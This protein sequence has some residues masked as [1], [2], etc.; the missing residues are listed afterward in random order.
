MTPF[1]EKYG[2]APCAAADKSAPVPPF[3]LANIPLTSPDA[4]LIA[5]DERTP[6]EETCAMPVLKP[7]NV[8]VPPAV[9]LPM[10]TKL[11]LTSIRCVP[12]PAPVLMPVVPFTVVPVIVFAVA[13]VPKPFAIEPA[14][15]APTLVN[16]ELTTPVPNVV[17]FLSL[18]HI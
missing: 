18:I 11:P 3:A 7:E 9:M 5:P 8:I 14:A 6:A 15:N 13:M 16:D 1:V 10:L 17:E 4:R 12:A 2:S